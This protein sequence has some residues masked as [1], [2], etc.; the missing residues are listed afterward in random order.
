[1]RRVTVTER[2]ARLGRRHRLSA[3]QRCD[4]VTEVARSLVALHSTD[5][6]TVFLAAAARMA[7]PKVVAIE[8][9]LYEHRSLVR[10]LGMRRT[11][12]V[13]PTE[14][15]PVVH[16]GC[17]VAIAAR[18]RRRLLKLLQDVGITDDTAAWLAAVEQ[19]TLQALKD[20]GGAFG[21]ELSTAVPGLRTRYV[22]AEGKSYGGQQNATTQILNLMSMDGAIVRGRPRG[23]WNN[24]QY[25]WAPIER[26]L[27]EGM[28][29]LDRVDA[30]AALVEGW[31]RAF[32]PGTIGDLKWWTGLNLG[33]V[34]TAL[35]RLA[36]VEV[37]LDGASG[38][39]LADDLEPVEPPGPWIALLPALDP[40]AMGWSGRDWYLG[41]HRSRLFDRSGNIGPTVWADGRIVGGWAQRKSTGDV[42]FRLFEDVGAEAAT[43]IETEAE[44]LAAWIGDVRVTPRFRTPV[45]RE[46]TG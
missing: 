33:E 2:R 20:R 21:T 46:L 4:D 42:V 16:A 39:L 7:D 41:D 3:G 29:A 26:W 24:S 6:A 22:Y 9:A 5:P 1:M 35:V 11:M 23:A 17:T 18:E 32:G 31:L 10:M 15:V 8:D 34:R 44:R 27:P 40:T 36:V 12:W 28:A 13:A 19:A 37:D 43:A 30:H 25:R 14:L 45:E 38:L